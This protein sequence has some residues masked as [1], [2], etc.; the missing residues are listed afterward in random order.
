MI[1]IKTRKYT[2]IGYIALWTLMILIIFIIQVKL[3]F[4]KS[5]DMAEIEAISTYEADLNFRSWMATHGGV[6]IPIT[7]ETQPNPYLKNIPEQNIVTPNGVELTLMNP[8]WAIRSL[9][10]YKKSKTS[11]KSHITSLN[12][13]RPENAPDEWETSALLAFEKGTPDVRGV[14]PINNE[15]YFRYMK[16]LIV[17]QGC[18]K[19]HDY[20]GYEIGDIHGAISSVIAQAA[21]FDEKPVFFADL[22]IRH[23]EDDNAELLWHCGPFPLSLKKE[24]SKAYVSNQLILEGGCPGTG[25]WEI[26]GGNLSI[27][28]FFF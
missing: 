12:L 2:T 18:L 21:S 9:N 10:E 8:A 20:Q 3:E 28:I 22:T 6:Y 16:P 19:C 11:A 25:N 15:S 24:G 13:L 4:E 7:A 14:F 23:P 1:R 26:K 5:I 27:V 17:E